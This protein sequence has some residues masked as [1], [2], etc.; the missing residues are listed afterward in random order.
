MGAVGRR[1]DSY[2]SDSGVF[3]ILPDVVGL[4][5]EEEQKDHGAT[6]KDTRP[7]EHPLPALIL[8]DESTDDWCEEVAARQKE[9]VETHVRS[10]LVCEVLALSACHLAPMTRNAYHIRHR[11]LGEGF[12]GSS[13]KARD[14]VSGNPLAFGVC[15]GSD[16]VLAII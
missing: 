11:D 10:S 6:E 7:V 13:E 5:H 9:G 4:L 16:N 2:I 12:D 1:A 14:D 8:G 15:V 3:D